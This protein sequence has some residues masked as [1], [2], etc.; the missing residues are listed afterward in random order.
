M[1]VGIVISAS[2][3]VFDNLQIL[4]FALVVFGFIAVLFIPIIREIVVVSLRHP[5]ST[6]HL[7]SPSLTDEFRR[8][9]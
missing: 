8:H 2:H 4:A 1:V 7:Q 6:T 3:D 5:L 9:S